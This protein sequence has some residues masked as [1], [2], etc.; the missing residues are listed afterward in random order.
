MADF[1]WQQR[2]SHVFSGGLC[3][4]LGYAAYLENSVFVVV[5]IVVGGGVVWRTIHISG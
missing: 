5:S 1:S 2:L 3:I 4:T